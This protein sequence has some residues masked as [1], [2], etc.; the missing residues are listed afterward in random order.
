MY[1]FLYSN[2]GIRELP[3]E[4]GQ[5]ANLWQL[6]IEELSIS[7][8]PAEIRKEGKSDPVGSLLH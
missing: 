4:L 5:L 2:P 1:L 6:D 7:N 8:V 3:P